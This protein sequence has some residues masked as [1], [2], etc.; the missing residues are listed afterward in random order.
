M[1]VF[2]V[3]SCEWHQKQP[4]AMPVPWA[5]QHTH[6]QLQMQHRAFRKAMPRSVCA[7]WT[8]LSPTVGL[9]PVCHILKTNTTD[10]QHSQ[11]KTNDTF[12]LGSLLMC[13]YADEN[14]NTYCV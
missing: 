3:F 2:Y 5:V 12:K 1:S 10:A 11:A 8:T 14:T 4:G 7:A 9:M 6:M 13:F